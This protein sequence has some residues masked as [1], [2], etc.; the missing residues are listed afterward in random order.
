MVVVKGDT[1]EVVQNRANATLATVSGIRDLGLQLAVNNTQAVVFK[2]QYRAVD[3]HLRIH[4][5]TV[6]LET[7]LK[8]LGI[9][10]ENKGTIYG[11]HWCAIADKALRR[12]NALTGL[13]P[14]IGDP[15]KSRRRLL[16]TMLRRRKMRS[17]L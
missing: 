5:Q 15:R 4:G 14:N 8:Y 1:A 10:L 3:V 12:M 2:S 17:T 13:T 7:S 11:A 9:T 16:I 6:P